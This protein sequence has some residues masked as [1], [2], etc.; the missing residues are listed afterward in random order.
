MPRGIR[1]FTSF[2]SAPVSSMLPNEIVHQI[3]ESLH[4]HDWHED[5]IHPKRQDL[6]SF[7]QVSR[8]WRDVGQAHLFRSITVRLGRR[9]HGNVLAGNESCGEFNLGARLANGY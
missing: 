4:P 6:S 2:S 3:A 8:A 5:E 9:L 1:T 7:S